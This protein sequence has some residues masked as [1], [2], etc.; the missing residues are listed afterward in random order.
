[1]RRSAFVAGVILII[2]F[3]GAGPVSAQESTRCTFE[4]EVILS[5]GLSFSG[6][7][8]THGSQS[9]GTLDCKGLVNGK[10]PTATGTLGEEGNYGTANP[11]TCQAGGEGD[12]VDTLRVP[13]AAGFETVVSEF[14][15]TFGN[16]VPTHG[17]LA[18]GEFKGTHFTGTFE[19]TPT[20]GDCITAPVTK[21]RVVG[22][23]IIHG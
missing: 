19:F 8:G 10:Q 1:M 22:E 12:G 9:P 4:F 11:A 13:T 6:S 18:A 2:G 17:G 16:K 20:E 7:S 3:G 23:G 14:T 15:F 21:A 5:P